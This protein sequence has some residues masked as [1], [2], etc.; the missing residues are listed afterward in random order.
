MTWLLA[1]AAAL[2]QPTPAAPLSAE[3]S[4]TATSPQGEYEIRYAEHRL[5]L[6]A[7]TRYRA[8]V[9]APTQ[10]GFPTR[11]EI[12]QGQSLAQSSGNAMFEEGQPIPDER[13]DFVAPRTGDYQ[14]RVYALGPEPSGRYSVRVI[15]LPPLPEASAAP[16]T[17]T[18]NGNWQIWTATLEESDPVYIIDHHDDYPLEIRAGETLVATVESVGGNHHE[19]GE[20]PRFKLDVVSPDNP[21]G[22]PLGGDEGFMGHDPALAFQPP[23]AGVYILRVLGGNSD[24]TPANYRLRV[25]KIDSGR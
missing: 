7:G 19:P 5:R 8:I 20:G 6:V 1:L 24:Q 10:G 21:D 18:E 12:R 16:A 11:L 4:V 13:L 25:T 14:L 17:G 22:F 2:A 3:G 9:T 23:R 15:S